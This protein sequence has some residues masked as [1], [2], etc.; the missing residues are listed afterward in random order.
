MTS[1]PDTPTTLAPH[2]LVLGKFL[3]PHHGHLRL[4]AF[5]RGLCVRLTVVVGTLPGEPIP[6]EVRVAWMR[7]LVSDA[8]VVHLP[9]LLPQDPAEHPDF[10]SLWRAALRRVVR[11]PI[12]L[13][14]AG[15]P[16]GERL[17]S[18]LGARFVPLDR[19]R[20]P[21]G[22]RGTAVRADPMGRWADLPS[23]V[24]PWF[25]R[26]VRVVG[27]ESAGKTTLARRLAQHFE[28]VWVPEYA[29]TLLES[30]G[31]RVTP[32]DLTLIAQ[33]QAADEQATAE[34]ANRV[35]ICDTDP[36]LTALWSEALFGTVAP[37][38]VALGA[39]R[40][41]GVTLLLAP[42]LDW[43]P[44]P[45]RYQPDAA[46]RWRFFERCRATYPEA[47]CMV[48]EG[49]D[50]ARFAGAVRAIEGLLAAPPDETPPGKAQS[51]A[52]IARKD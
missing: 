44:D 17:A 35:L 29:R 48:L 1:R 30:R 38:V 13:V 46:D 49:T 45:V 24:R 6:G 43:Q 4:C 12:D 40:T 36:T 19:G 50:D 18:E 33:A 52:P 7:R 2:A 32:A 31:G 16:Y 39:T 27:P 37:A 8:E 5:A 28:T 3:P 14:V 20:D 51:G 26:R 41:Y 42:R 9:D 10:W 21:T 22:A 23:C 11:G 47:T 25:V 34:R 15:E